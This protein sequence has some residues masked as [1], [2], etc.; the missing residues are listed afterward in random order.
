MGL[1]YYKG[2]DSQILYAEETAFGTGGT[3][4]GTNR[5]GKVQGV[6]INMK[7]NHFKTGAMGEGRNIVSTAP[8]SFEVDGSI[9]WEVDDFTFM[10]YSIGK[11]AG[12]GTL[13]DPYELQELNNIG[14]AATDIKSLKLEVGSE[15]ATDDAITL[16]GVV[17]KDL[18]ITASVGEVLKASCS[19]VA[20]TVSTAA[21]FTSYTASTTKVLTF[22]QGACTVGSDTCPVTNFTWKLDNSIN[23]F[24]KLNSR[25]I[26]QPVTGM[27]LYTFSV[28]LRHN[29][30]DTAS[31][32][33]GKELR[34]L[35]LGS[36]AATSP[37]TI[38]HTASTVKLA[39]TEGAAT[40]DRVV[41]I[42]LEN[43]YFESWSQPMKLDG[44]VIE[45]SVD[46]FGFAGLD[47]TGVKIPIRYYII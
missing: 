16:T 38:N 7:N 15:G 34:S 25:F 28:T 46:G 43:A 42:D 27:R 44:G 19:F 24:G 26:E 8:G 41:S 13:I 32:L 39:I 5:V 14:Y 17:I 30:D 45:V 31:V 33:S 9:E 35:F 37:A 3:L 10:Q 23:T 12:S 4:A 22:V 36:A 1:V 29:F 6:T 21:S 47:D 2:F 11:R 40:G 20:K 18:S